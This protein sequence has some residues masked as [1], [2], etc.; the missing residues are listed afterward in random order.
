MRGLLKMEAFHKTRP[1]REF[2]KRMGS[3]PASVLPSSSAVKF[4]AVFKVVRDR[5]ERMKTAGR[6]SFT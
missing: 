5:Y 3:D 6:G 2:I 4:A 1:A